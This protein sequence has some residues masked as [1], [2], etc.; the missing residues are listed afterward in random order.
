MTRSSDRVRSSTASARSCSASPESNQAITTLESSTSVCATRSLTLARRSLRFALVAPLAPQLLQ[1]ALGIEPREDA[2]IAM[3]GVLIPADDD[4]T[5]AFGF[6]PNL[7]SGLEPCLPQRRH[8]DRDLILGADT[9]DAS[10]RLSPHLYYCHIRV[11][12]TSP[13]RRGQ[14]SGTQQV[15][16]EPLPRATHRVDHVLARAEAVSFT[17]VHVVLVH[18]ARRAQRG[19]DLLRLGQRYPRVVLALEDEQRRFDLRDM[20]QR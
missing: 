5:C 18:L 9:G 8:G 4:T 6:D 16:V 11:K 12:V 20:R 1:V 7:A 19:H 10:S 2:R 17:L 13:A 14:A 15:A 3:N